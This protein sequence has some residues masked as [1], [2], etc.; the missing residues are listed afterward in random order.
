MAA[1][2][3]AREGHLSNIID[4]APPKGIN[5]HLK[6]QPVAKVP[7]GPLVLGVV[8]GAGVGVKPMVE[9]K[10]ALVR[11]EFP[12]RGPVE[13]PVGPEFLSGPLEQSRSSLRLAAEFHDD[14]HD[15]GIVIGVVIQVRTRTTRY[16]MIRT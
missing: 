5:G 3:A 4:V 11:L 14:R 13:I 7:G 15:P 6:P 9:I 8:P 12:P 10:P 1:L 2:P 16:P